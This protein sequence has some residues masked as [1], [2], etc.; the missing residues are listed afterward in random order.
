MEM[1]LEAM[2]EFEEPAS[3]IAF[4]PAGYH[5]VVAFVNKIRI[6]NIFLEDA[7]NNEQFG[8]LSTFKD[9]GVK[10]CEEIQFSPGGQF[11]ALCHQN[12]I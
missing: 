9:I 4:H 10:K 11:F 3:A 12:K 2:K 8:T 6:L 5:L 7:Q 1:N